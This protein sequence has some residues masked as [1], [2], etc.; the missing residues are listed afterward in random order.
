MLRLR[1]RGDIP[2]LLRSEPPFP[3]FCRLEGQTTHC[4]L[5]STGPLSLH[6]GP[7]V[8]MIR[9]V[10]GRQQN[11]SPLSN[12][13]QA[14]SMFQRL[15]YFLMILDAATCSSICLIGCTGCSGNE[16]I[17][18]TIAE[19]SCECHPS[20]RQSDPLQ[21]G[22]P[23]KECQR[24]CFCK[25]AV[26]ATPFQHLVDDSTNAFAAGFVASLVEFQGT[27]FDLLRSVSPA[28]SCIE[29]PVLTGADVHA[30][31]CSWQC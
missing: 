6:L 26:V 4:A 30:L 13:M 14:E 1:E 25:G 5:G 17:R 28:R 15:V 16:F 21:S 20:G 9:I 7:T 11:G 27:T 10:T 29:L 3:E 31:H 18:A 2:K 22:T 24:C 12:S 19:T 8:L 23:A